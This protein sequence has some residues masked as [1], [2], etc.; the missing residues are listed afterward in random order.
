MLREGGKP[1]SAEESRVGILRTYTRTYLP[2]TSSHHTFWATPI[3]GLTLHQQAAAFPT[4]NLCHFQGKVS[5]LL[6][7]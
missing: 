6:R 1:H 4:A 5:Y 2:A 7:Y 3:H